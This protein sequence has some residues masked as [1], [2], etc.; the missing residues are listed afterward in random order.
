[1]QL[2]L[3]VPLSLLYWQ[4]PAF[5]FESV[6]YLS[7][8]SIFPFCSWVSNALVQLGQELS[9]LVTKQLSVLQCEIH[10]MHFS[11]SGKSFDNFW[12]VC[13]YYWDL[14]AWYIHLLLVN[15]TK[16][17]TYKVEGGMG[18]DTISASHLGIWSS[19]NFTEFRNLCPSNHGVVE[20]T[21]NNQGLLAHSP[22]VIL[23]APQFCVNSELTLLWFI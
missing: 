20:N 2:E 15:L 12:V 1:M 13:C 3:F 11:I 4:W 8:N 23:T 22:L 19:F 21:K 7:I 5:N 9:N 6:L 10:H 17:Q 16:P 14:T 18:K